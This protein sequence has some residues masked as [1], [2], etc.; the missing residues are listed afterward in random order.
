L[1]LDKEV[2]LIESQELK[3]LH[4]HFETEPMEVRNEQKILL[5]ID[6]EWQIRSFRSEPWRFSGKQL[7]L[8]DLQMRYS[9][10]ME[11]RRY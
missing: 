5:N 2:A 11:P 3:T 1:S 9:G 10:R 8:Q 6:Y 4:R 7:E